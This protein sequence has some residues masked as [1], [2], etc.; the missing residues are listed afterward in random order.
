MVGSL[1]PEAQ[2]S[3]IYQ[4]PF[5]VTFFD[6]WVDGYWA[7]FIICLP[8]PSNIENALDERKP[9]NAYAGNSFWTVGLHI[10]LTPIENKNGSDDYLSYLSEFNNFVIKLFHY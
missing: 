10:L 7:R 1:A 6:S 2:Q 3:S 9:P 5:F 8:H 4:Y